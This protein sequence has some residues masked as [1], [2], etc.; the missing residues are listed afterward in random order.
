MLVNTNTVLNY[1]R[2]RRF[3]AL[4]DPYIASYLKGE[5]EEENSLFRDIFLSHIYNPNKEIKKNITLTYEFEREITLTENYN[6]LV[7]DQ[8]FYSLLPYTSTDLLNLKY[9]DGTHKY[10]V[11][12]KNQEGVYTLRNNSINNKS[13]RE[14]LDKLYAHFEPLGKIVLNYALKQYIISKVYPEKK[15]KLYFVLL[16]PDYQ[17]DGISYTDKLYTIFDFSKLNDLFELVEISLFR[18]INHL[19][20]N[21]FT[22]CTLVKK[23]CARGKTN[24]C[25]FVNFCYSHLPENTSILDYINSHY[26]FNEPTDEGHVHHDEYDL[27]NSGY[28][29]MQDIPISWLENQNHLMQRYCVDN[30][31]IFFHNDKIKAGLKELKFPIIYLDFEALPLSIPKFK[32]E[33]PYTQS[34]FQYSVHIEEIEDDLQDISRNHF[35]FIANPNKDDREELLVTLLK[36]LNQHESSIVVYNKT[37]EKTRL[38]ELKLIFPQYENQIDRVISRLFDLLDVVKMNKSFYKKLNFSDKDLESYNLYSPD[39]GGSYSLKKVIKL[40]NKNAYEDLLIN[41][42]VKAYKAYKKIIESNAIETKE[43]KKNLFLYCRQDTYSMY[44][45]IQGLKQLIGPD[46]KINN[47]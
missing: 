39:F 23:A 18:M 38:E 29:A 37:F 7:D 9:K 28:V 27:L 3:A 8:V 43:I 30:Q 21:D 25:K 32:G 1:N 36:I 45:I 24:E 44:Q 16:N 22:P 2:C 13:F 40:F 46:F 19:E 14:K 15:Y 33:K 35:S 17:Y 26:G 5:F 12:T 42:G 31:T 47:S 20:L 10:Q 41:D 4:N 11:F 6:F 34:V